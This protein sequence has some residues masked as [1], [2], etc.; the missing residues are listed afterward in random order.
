[1]QRELDMLMV[2]CEGGRGRS[3]LCVMEDRGEEGSAVQ[4]VCPAR[5]TLTNNGEESIE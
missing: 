2:I 5:K 4:P 3:V 1:M